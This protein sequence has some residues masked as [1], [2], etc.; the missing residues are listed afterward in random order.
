MEANQSEE[1]AD[2]YRFVLRSYISCLYDLLSRF[3]FSLQRYAHVPL[4]AR[5]RVPLPC[6]SAPVRKRF[7]PLARP[8]RARP[9]FTGE[10]WPVALNLQLTIA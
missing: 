5:S 10:V 2:A 6:S 9:A 3:R 4:P 1:L 8:A 7:D